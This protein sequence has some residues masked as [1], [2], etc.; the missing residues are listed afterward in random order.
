MLKRL[1]TCRH[2]SQHLLFFRHHREAH[3]RSLIENTSDLITILDDRGRITYLSPSNARII[4]YS[5]D[6]V[7]GR[8]A[9]DFVHP[10]DLDQALTV[11]DKRLNSKEFATPSQFQ[12]RQGMV[13][14][15]P[16]KRPAIT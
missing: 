11:F 9:F 5:R 15:G 6:S 13:H 12:F 3:F 1:A 7:M 10:E 16:L 4:G 14:G 8:Q 2:H